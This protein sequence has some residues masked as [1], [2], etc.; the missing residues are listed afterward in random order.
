M[1]TFVKRKRRGKDVICATIRI[2]GYP[3]ESATFTKKRAAVEWAT[4]IEN[5][6]RMG[7][8]LK[9]SIA[10]QRSFSE[11]IDR[12]IE[13]V[14]FTKSSKK[15]FI[16][17]QHVQLLWWKKHLGEHTLFNV[18]SSE[19]VQC[20]DILRKTRAP[21]TVNC[22]LAVL[23][24]VY[25]KACKEWKWLNVNPMDDVEKFKEP[26]GIVRFLSDKE[27]DRLLR[28]LEN[29]NNDIAK[30]V[31]MLSL[32]TGARKSEVTGLKWEDYDADR[33][34]IIVQETKNGER[35]QLPLHG[36]CREWFKAYAKGRNRGGY[37]FPS[38]Y[39]RQP[40]DVD[41]AW[42]KIVKAAR[43]RDFRFHDLRHTAASFMAMQNVPTTTIAEVLGHK[44]L[45]MVKRYAHLSEGH[46]SDAVKKMN[47]KI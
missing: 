12:Y 15:R 25:S 36:K 30:M 8:Y 5:E 32:S 6:M 4:E 13:L 24:H 34:I 10:K 43:L 14:L 18:T 40:Y 11:M 19:I 37:V 9:N 29:S 46:V 26:R 41:R 27:L 42:R 33:N 28:A 16:Q 1:A 7:R 23:S 21:G 31:V 47:S 44:T 17:Q 22:Y 39:K 35:R 2:A 38:K 20:R 45:A 3:T